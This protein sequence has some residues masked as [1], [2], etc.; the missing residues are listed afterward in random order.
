MKLNRALEESAL[1]GR[2]VFVDVWSTTC[3]N[4]LYMDETTF[5]APEVEDKL[6]DYIAVKFQIEDFTAPAAVQLLNALESPGLPT[7]GVLSPAE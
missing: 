6:K 3:K 2:P 5:K 4:C 1:T 7:V